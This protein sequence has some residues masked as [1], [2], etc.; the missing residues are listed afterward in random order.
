MGPVVSDKSKLPKLR[1]NWK[2]KVTLPN[3]EVKAFYQLTTQEILDLQKE[4]FG[5]YY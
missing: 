1:F 5:K 2:T 4:E 3:G